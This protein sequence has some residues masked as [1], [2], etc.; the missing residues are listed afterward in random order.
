VLVM[1]LFFSAPIAF[2]LGNQN[3]YIIRS[4][5][6]NWHRVMFNYL[7]GGFNSTDSQDAQSNISQN[8]EL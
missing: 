5:V 1:K 6:L 8:L 2:I 3:P 4:L 7:F